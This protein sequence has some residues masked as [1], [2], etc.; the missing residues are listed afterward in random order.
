MAN[1][2]HMKHLRAVAMADVACLEEKERTYGGSWKR[3]A[4]VGAF[5]MLARKW[6]RLE[7]ILQGGWAWDIFRAIDRQCNDERATGPLNP[8]GGDGTVLAEVRDLRRYLLLVEAEM[9]AQGS[10]P[11]P[12]MLSGLGVQRVEI[13]MPGTPED[14]GHHAAAQ[15]H[16]RYDDGLTERPPYPYIRVGGQETDGDEY[17]ITNRHVLP[18]ED[19]EHL[20]RLPVELTYKEWSDTVPYYQGLYDWVGNK[21]RMKPGRRAEWGKE[22]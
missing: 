19:W 18:K 7:S 1:D 8:V 6:D 13:N 17:Y 9:V 20:P 4:G 15:P 14:G 16:E 10:V 22:P 5:M 3:R 2:D 11:L 21:Y 12:N